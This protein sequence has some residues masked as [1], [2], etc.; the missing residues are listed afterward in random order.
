MKRNITGQ[1]L[2]VTREMVAKCIDC[3]ATL[4]H[5]VWIMQERTSQKVDRN[6]QTDTAIQQLR[7][8]RWY[9]RSTG[10]RQRQTPLTIRTIGTRLQREGAGR[11]QLDG[12]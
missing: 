4:L 10:T 12:S 7:L 11:T 9:N 1:L 8:L 6:I 5:K 2:P 3:P